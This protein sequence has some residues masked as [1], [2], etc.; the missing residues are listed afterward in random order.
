MRGVSGKGGAEELVQRKNGEYERCW[1]KR[2]AERM[3]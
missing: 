3:I 2:D 1:W